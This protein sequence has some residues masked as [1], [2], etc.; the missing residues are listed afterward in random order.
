MRAPDFWFAPKP[1]WRAR[2]LQP[3]G[4]IY[5]AVTSWKMRQSGARAGVPVV[6]VGNFVAGG[7][8]KTPVA[9]AVAALLAEMGER[10]VFLSRGYGGR[11]G[12]D[13]A[14]RVSPD[15]DAAF[16]GDEPLL[17]AR[18]APTIVCADRRIGAAAARQAGASVIVMDD[19]LQNRSLHQDLRFAVVDGASGVGNGLCVP[20]G[21]LRAPL[22]AQ[23]PQISAI[24]VVGAGAAG[25]RVADAAAHAGKPVLRARLEPA[26]SAAQALAGRDVVAFAGIGRPEK[27]FATLAGIG[28]RVVS[29]QAFGD[30]H[31]F[32]RE[33]IAG[34]QAEAAARGAQLATTEKDLARLGSQLTNPLAPQPMAL[35]VTLAFDAP[36]A[37]KDLLRAM[38]TPDA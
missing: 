18:A 14:V 37:V 20:A 28:A 32:T 6:C 27:F 13:A 25:A 2:A 11:A 4:V 1:D 12:K 24:V 5:G 7:A 33:E 23:I 36:A 21:P 31:P 26:L 3:L 10:P 38:L 19:G 15:H 17:L 29:A 8:G 30:H 9:L 22:A 16:V 35:P 34:L